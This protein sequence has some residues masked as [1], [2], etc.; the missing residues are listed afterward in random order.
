MSTKKIKALLLENDGLAS[1]KIYNWVESHVGKKYKEVNPSTQCYMRSDDFH[2]FTLLTNPN[3]EQIFV[4]SAFERCVDFDCQK[5]FGK[6]SLNEEPMKQVEYF[7]WIIREAVFHRKQNNLPKLTLNIEYY[8]EN[9]IGDIQYGKLGDMTT[10]IPL[11]IRQAEGYL[12]LNVYKEFK[13]LY[14]VVE[15]N[16]SWKII[17]Y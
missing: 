13:P 14:S 17:A 8:G 5:T 10:L 12:T 4:A 7:S 1:Q 6:R 11:T 3:I 16:A 15:D 2:W 9:L